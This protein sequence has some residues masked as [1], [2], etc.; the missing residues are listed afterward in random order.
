MISW[1]TLHIPDNFELFLKIPSL[2]IQVSS[3]G[4]RVVSNLSAKRSRSP[5]K[6]DSSKLPSQKR[7][8]LLS[9][10]QLRLKNQASSWIESAKAELCLMKRAFCYIK[11]ARFTLEMAVSVEKE[12]SFHQASRFY[13]DA[14][15]TLRVHGN[16]TSVALLSISLK[17]QAV[18]SNYLY[19]MFAQENEEKIKLTPCS[20]TSGYSSSFEGEQQHSLEDFRLTA[21]SFKSQGEALW[22]NSKKPFSIRRKQPEFY[23]F[24]QQLE[25]LTLLSKCDELVLFLSAGLNIYHKRQLI[26]ELFDEV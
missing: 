17:A 24:D 21:S 7:S 1:I 16:C 4:H 12:L 19:K 20:F 14:L 18:I 6:L 8:R 22:E 23:K 11:S 9:K 13:F 25:K 5:D 10:E 3:Q 2:K 26:R 15:E